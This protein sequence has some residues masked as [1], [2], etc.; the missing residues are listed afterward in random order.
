[1]PIC[2]G[3]GGCRVDTGHYDA[4]RRA[5]QALVNDGVG[6]S[7]LISR[8]SGC[9]SSAD[10]VEKVRPRKIEGKFSLAIPM[11]VQ[12]CIAR[13]YAARPTVCVRSSTIRFGTLLDCSPGTSAVFRVDG[14]LFGLPR[15]L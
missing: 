15:P 5:T 13:T 9:P 12:F 10:G 11:T 8:S 2:M 1:M 7:A 4:L 14:L 3:S 6:S